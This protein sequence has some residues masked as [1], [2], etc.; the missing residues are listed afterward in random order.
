MKKQLLTLAAVSVFGSA[1]MLAQQTLV[2]PK[3]PLT[4][5]GTTQTPQHFE[6]CGSPIPS[7][8]WNVQFNKLV[9]EYTAQHTSINGK[10]A[11]V[12]ATI[13]V[14]VHIIHNGTAVGSGAN[15]SA[16]Q[17]A[18][19]ITVLNN[20]FAGTNADAANIPSIFQGVK[21]GDT[22][23]Q[24]CLATID[25]NGNTMAEPGIERMTYQAAGA[26]SDPNTWSF[27]AFQGNFDSEIK[28]TTIW[29][30]TKYMNIWVTRANSSQL[31]G[32]ASFPAAS[33]LTGL[34]GVEDQTTSGVVINYQGFGT[35]GTAAAPY[36]KG[37]TATHE[38]GHWL[39]LRHISGDNANC[40]ATNDY[41]ND[42]P[43][44]KGGY[45]GGQGGLNYGCPPFP[46]LAS[47]ECTGANSATTATSEMFMNYMDYCDDACLYMF[48]A[49]QKTRM[50]TAM[51]NGT[52]RK[53]LGTH[54]LCG[55]AT[56]A[57]PV[58]AF[59]ISATGCVGSGVSVTNS[60][61]GSPAPTYAW[62]ANPS[63]G[64]T[65]SS[66]T[67]SAPTITFANTGTYTISV[68][69]TNSQGSSS[70]N[71]SI[72]VN[73]CTLSACDTLA[74]LADTSTLVMYSVSSPGSGY[75]TGNNSYGDKAKAEYYTQAGITGSNVT[76]MIVYFYKNGN[77][78]TGGNASGTLSFE[79]FNGNNSTGPAG[80]AVKTQAVTLGTIT[81]NG[82]PQGT[83]LGYVH[84]YT[85]PYTLTAN[86]FIASIKLPTTAGDTAVVYSG[87]FDVPA[88]NT[89]W[90]MYG[91][92]WYNLATNWQSNTASLAIFPTVC[93]ASIGLAASELNNKV[94]IYP[95][96]SSGIINI[97]YVIENS[98]VTIEVT[99]MLG[100]VVYSETEK[101]NSVAAKT[102]DLSAHSKG[103]YMVTV[104]AG[105]E[106]MVRKVVIE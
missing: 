7:E 18:S 62:S 32:Y 102:I 51:T 15:I 11:T 21:A 85:T 52:Y 98:D 30:P 12:P 79:I 38:I 53:L 105:K 56:P 106:K 103:V 96:P 69:A 64:V 70:A 47:G 23:I 46:Y 43:T 33:G 20:D 67:A 101:N 17:V 8:E 94:S 84:Q 74:N 41:C 4:K 37:R 81:T 82:I 31:L 92:T 61:T 71:Q 57:A 3:G 9:E 36:N 104:K 68:T 72:V 35:M 14:I 27:S 45:S 40:T 93:P 1:S 6:R 25:K 13:P 59:T 65:F 90:E 80:A 63:A 78:G 88:T 95:N 34:S 87:M 66:S 89:A 26:S 86:E 91:T 73:N 29:D 99:N 58:A 60:T 28:P 22:Q 97:A 42:T 55:A 100:Q 44:Q 49:N 75:V 48:S 76:G 39:G 5:A 16:A 54:G 83:V 10:V 50:Q 24:F 19:Q 2:N 77:N